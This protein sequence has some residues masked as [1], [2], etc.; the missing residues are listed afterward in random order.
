MASVTEYLSQLQS[1]TKKNLDILK[2]LNDSFFTKQNHLHINVD[3]SDYVIPSFISLENKI[4]AL[5]ENFSNLI[6]SP[7]SGE[8]SFHMD[9][10]TRS[11]EVRSYEKAPNPITLE[12]TDKFSTQQNDIFKDFLT[13][14]PF[15]N[16][17]LSN[18]PNDIVSVNIKK[19]VPK[20]EELISLF[21]SLLNNS[22]SIQYRYSDM[23]KHLAIYKEDEDYIEYN[24]IRKLPIRKNIGSSTYVIE[25]IKSDTIDKNLDN[26]ITLKLRN[27]LNGAEYSNN[28]TYKLFDETIEKPLSIGDEL[29]TYDGTGKMEI[30][31]IYSNINTIEVRVVN[32]EFLNLIGTDQYGKNTPISD[33][34]KIR[35][36]SPIDFDNDKYIDIPLEEDRYIFIA[37][38]P[39]NDRMNIQSPWGG[40]VIFD[41]YGLKNQFNENFDSY[42]QNNVHNIGDILYEITS[43]MTNT[44]TKFTGSEFERLSTI[45]PEINTGDISVVQ[46]NKHIN[47]SITVKNIRALYSQKK[48]YNTELEEVQVKIDELNNKLTSI[49]FD[50][51]S[52]IRTGYV[53]QLTSYNNKKNELMTSITKIIDE[54]SKSVNDAEIPIE[55]AKYRIRGFFDYDEFIDK[56]GLTYLKNHIN[57]IKVQY[58]YKTLS[59]EQGNAMSMSKGFIF[60]DWNEMSGFINKKIPS[61]N[62]G[63]SFNLPMNNNTLNEPSFNQIDIPISQGE[64]VDIRL[65]V[66]YDFGYP[67]IETTSA[68]SDIVNIQFPEEFVKDIRVLDIISEN[69]NDIETNRFNNI[70]KG[71]GVLDHTNDKVSDQDIIYFH[72][73]ENISSGFY[74]SE[75]RIIPLKDK[76]TSMDNLIT[77]MYDELM[78]NSAS[79]LSI[80]ITNGDINNIIY[81][82]QINNISVAS[83]DTFIGGG[84]NSLI[85]EGLYNFNNSNK[86]V[87]TI[88]NIV[89]KNTSSHSIKLYS[90]FPGNRDL[91][92]GGLKNSKFDKDDFSEGVDKGVWIRSQFSKVNTNSGSNAGDWGSS[93]SNDIGNWDSSESSSNIGNWDGDKLKLQTCNQYIT[94]RT[95]DINTGQVYY[96]EGENWETDMLSLDEDYIILSEQSNIP[97]VAATIYPFIKEVKSLCLDSDS[98]NSYILL[99]PDQ[100]I[101]IPMVFEYKVNDANKYISKTISF[102]LRPSLYTDPINYTFK[103][104]AK[105]GQSIADKLL[106]TNRKQ[107]NS[108][109]YTTNVIV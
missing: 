81:P 7:L 41:T 95:K 67:F 27:D 65:K 108:K 38:A 11:I 53:A 88:L 92:L 22:T 87:S 18:L 74:T 44:L 9:G 29:V 13:P 98:I 77:Q 103:I 54:I 86:V 63:Y 50:D 21:K 46:I 58:R 28:L 94:F 14:I 91:V 79:A 25:S 64:T 31:N 68:W 30:T 12:A 32:G 73:P 10:N 43:M 83:Y 39:L 66:V 48:R 71:E 75:R 90:M 101:V 16:F 55:N 109:K 49:S 106:N 1:L 61:Y 72:K 104:T 96:E 78:G 2:A 51:N 82:W 80:S 97:N 85:S 15:V 8:A 19:I 45:I 70:L 42:Y 57:G 35:F 62:N 33:L 69:N 6:N 3:G 100:E 52:N 17:N 59:S 4:N 40:G 20:N 84:S 5:E 24:T 107:F 47:D 37:V 36:Y 76:L 89:I 60:S 56:T 26:Y 34:S 102:D 23:F 105:N 99:T 93:S